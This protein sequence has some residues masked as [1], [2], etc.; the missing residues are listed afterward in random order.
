M[1]RKYWE[2]SI[3]FLWFFFCSKKVDMWMNGDSILMDF[4]GSDIVMGLSEY[5]QYLYEG[6]LFLIV[7]MDDLVRFGL[8]MNSLV[9]I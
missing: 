7:Y 8:I 2:A 3:G 4:F 9:S 5:Y 6:L 1:L